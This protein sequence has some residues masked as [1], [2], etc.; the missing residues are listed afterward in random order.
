MTMTDGSRVEIKREPAPNERPSI[1]CAL[2][3]LDRGDGDLKE[4][5]RSLVDGAECSARSR[6]VLR[7]I[8]RKCGKAISRNE[9]CLAPHQDRRGPAGEAATPPPSPSPAGGGG[10]A[11][12]GNAAR[13]GNRTS[14]RPLEF[15][16]STGSEEGRFPAF[17][18]D[19]RRLNVVT[20]VDAQ[21]IPRI[22]DTMDALA[23]AKWFSTLDLASGY[24]QRPVKDGVLHAPGTLPILRHAVQTAECPGDVSA[25]DGESAKAGTDVEN[26]LCLPRWYYRLWEDRGGVFGAVRRGAVPPS[27]RGTEDQLLFLY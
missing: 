1:G 17:C 2:G 10:S 22:D 12:P 13:G 4:W 23:G 25:L 26:M 11:N 15:T 20:C 18:V 6:R 7:S 24:W 21:P 3:K 19:Y 14:L 8:L 27:I 9:P 16:G 5:G